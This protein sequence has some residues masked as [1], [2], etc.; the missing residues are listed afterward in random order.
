[1]ETQVKTTHF[2]TVW[3]GLGVGSI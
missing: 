1:L 3:F 2:N